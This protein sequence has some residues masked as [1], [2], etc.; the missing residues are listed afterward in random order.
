MLAARICRLMKR[1]RSMAQTSRPHVSEQHSPALERVGKYI[2][3]LLVAAVLL[4][5]VV[6][7]PVSH[8]AASNQIH[9]AKTETVR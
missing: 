8:P 5:R 1:F 6:Y 4:A 7:F 3:W 2:F 9:E